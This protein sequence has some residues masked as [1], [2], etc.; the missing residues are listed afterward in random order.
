LHKSSPLHI[1][2]SRCTKNEPAGRIIGGLFYAQSNMTDTPPK[3]KRRRWRWLVLLLAAIS[4]AGWWYWPRGDARFVGKW[5][6]L[7][8][9]NNKT[10]GVLTLEAN[11]SGRFDCPLNALPRVFKWTSSG[12]RLQIGYDL[13]TS[14]LPLH[15]W[16][17]EASGSIAG[18]SP[19]LAH[20]SL[21]A[22]RTSENKMMLKHADGTPCLPVA[23]EWERLP[24]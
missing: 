2:S 13:P 8:W 22:E 20:Q 7:P 24:E 17:I 21:L 3:P 1:S 9:P 12:D 23:F 10:A 16:A 5:K 18:T 15:R 19:F 6:L 14:T 4:V 11:G